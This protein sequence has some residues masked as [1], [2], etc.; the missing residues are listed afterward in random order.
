MGLLGGGS[1]LWLSTE[2]ETGE[3]GGKDVLNE[4]GYILAAVLGLSDW[5]GQGSKE[6]RISWM[7]SVMSVSDSEASRCF[8]ASA[9]GVC[10][11]TCG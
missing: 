1:G 9:K 10:F 6:K 11:A 8:N 4:L 3:D 7:G 5:T 2:G